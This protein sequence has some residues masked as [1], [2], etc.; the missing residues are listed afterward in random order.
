MDV[1]NNLKIR[2]KSFLNPSNSFYPVQ[3]TSGWSI[4]N[5]W[6]TNAKRI[7]DGKLLDQGY[8]T[9][10]HVYSI[11]RLITTKGSTIPIDVFEGDNEVEDGDAWDLINPLNKSREDFIEESL[12][13]LLSTGDLF[14]YAPEVSTMTGSAT[15]LEMWN[16]GGVTINFTNSGEVQNYTYND[17]FKTITVQPEEVLHIKMFDPTL[18]GL[19][20]G[21]G[22][23]PLQAAYM[24]LTASNN[25]QT[26]NAAMLKNGGVKGI[27]SS[28]GG[29]DTLGGITVDNEKELKEIYN[30]KLGSPENFNGV[31]VTRAN[32][33]YTPIGSNASDLKIIESNV[34]DMRTLCNV[35]GMPSQLLNDSNNKT[36][37]NQ[38]AG[39]KAMV[40]NAVIPP[41]NKILR[42]IT[43][44]VNGRGNDWSY[45]P[46]TS[47]LLVLQEEKK[48]EAETKQI[49]SKNVTELLSAVT[50]GSITVDSAKNIMLHVWSMEEEVVDDLLKG[51]KVNE[52]NED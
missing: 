2:V 46:D 43:R 39:E 21:R 13:S 45:K 24:T 28:S 38:K 41:M 29:G 18:Y 52:S 1:L 16:A 7:D 22:L 47:E 34:V 31:H 49:V 44:F 26:A 33:D 8:V 9:N 20:S 27:L 14:F 51:A 35:F 6:D 42:G 36:Y 32:I 11:I 3:G 30:K 19:K 17:Q 50:L 10:A 37:N 15:V 40:E 23:S 12:T 48:Q 25:A 5:G 4:L